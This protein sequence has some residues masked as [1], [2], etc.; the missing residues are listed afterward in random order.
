[1]ELLPLVQARVRGPGRNAVP[2]YRIGHL[3]PYLLQLSARI[4]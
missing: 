3:T 2:L 1:M 4:P